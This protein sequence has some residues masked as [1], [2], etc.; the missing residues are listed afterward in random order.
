MHLTTTSKCGRYEIV[1]CLIFVIRHEA[2]GV[3]TG[4]AFC[5]VVGHRDRHE[6]TGNPKVLFENH[7]C[8]KV[9]LNKD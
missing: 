4:K 8:E 5:G 6:Y 9:F 7:V 1:L 3:A 2:I